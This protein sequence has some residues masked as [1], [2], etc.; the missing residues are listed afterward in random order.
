MQLAARCPA[1]GNVLRRR[2]RV[3]IS[4]T[5]VIPL[6]VCVAAGA[7]VAGEPSKSAPSV[8]WRSTTEAV[9]FQPYIAASTRF[10]F[11]SDGAR[12]LILESKTGRIA[13]EF[14]GPTD[15]LLSGPTVVR[16]GLSVTAGRTFLHAVDDKGR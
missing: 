13:G 1:T 9:M 11:I 7:A 8:L 14:R 15:E 5:K 16:E 6:V 10:A 2:I 3:A 12:I 4:T